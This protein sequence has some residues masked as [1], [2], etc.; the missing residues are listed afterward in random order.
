LIKGHR[1]I[2]D[3]YDP[4][5]RIKLFFDEWGTWHPEEEGKPK[6][7]LYQQNTMRD[8]CVAAI[9]LNAFNNNADKVEMANIAQLI[10]VLQALLLV[11][12]PNLIKT[13]T[14]HVF[15]L[16]KPHKGAVALRSIVSTD[17]ISDGGPSLPMV[18]R[19][20]LDKQPQALSRI[21][22][23]SSIKD[24]ILTVTVVNNHPTDQAEFEIKA[25]GASINSGDMVMLSSPDI[26]DHN[27]FDNPNKVKLASLQAVT[28]ANGAVRIELPPASIIRFSSKLS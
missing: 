21:H 26:H 25:I 27:T 12:G 24:D 16:Y 23:S 28:V 15:D 13:P 20:S 22:A 1:M 19:L 2:M 14:F 3:E 11:E 7:G 5:R 6:G 8:A 4:E 10:N 18:K 17:T 9:T